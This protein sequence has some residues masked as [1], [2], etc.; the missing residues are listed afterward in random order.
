MFLEV[1]VCVWGGGG[2]GT[3]S[4]CVGNTTLAHNCVYKLWV[5]FKKTGVWL[6]FSCFNKR[7]CHAG[8]SECFDP[9]SC[10]LQCHQL[11][12]T[13]LSEKEEF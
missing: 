12:G 8:G 1:C 4:F 11:C 6:Y 9:F 13:K 5:A 10:C 2:G 7:S 3:H